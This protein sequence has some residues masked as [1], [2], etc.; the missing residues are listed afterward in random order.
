MMQTNSLDHVYRVKYVGNV[1]NS[2]HC[3]KVKPIME[4]ASFFSIKLIDLWEGVLVM[5]TS[6]YPHLS[7]KTINIY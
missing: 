4:S 1:A 6:E 5:L 2:S 3:T 7:T